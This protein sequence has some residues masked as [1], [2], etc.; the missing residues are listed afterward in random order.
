MS[1]V[2]GN[3]FSENYFPIV[4]RDADREVFLFCTFACKSSKPVLFENLLSPIP[5]F[6][7]KVAQKYAT[8]THL[9]KIFIFFAFWGGMKEKIYK[10]AVIFLFY[11]I[12]KKQ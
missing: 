3:L 10:Q 11:L 12:S 6:A 1:I 8:I 4:L 7:L 2:L 9:R 5:R